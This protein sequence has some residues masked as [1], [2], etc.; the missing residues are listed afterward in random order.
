M[1]FLF[2]C[3][4]ILLQCISMS[5]S[6][7]QHPPNS[8]ER[9]PVF[10]PTYDPAEAEKSDI[11]G[12][13]PGQRVFP[14]PHRKTHPHEYAPI[15]DPKHR[16]TAP[17]T[18]HLPG[19]Q[20]PPEI[21]SN[22]HGTPSL[23]GSA[24]AEKTRLQKETDHIHGNQHEMGLM[25]NTWCTIG[26][27][28]VQIACDPLTER[29]AVVYRG[30]DR[31]R[32]DG[33][34]RRLFLRHSTDNGL[35]WA[36][37]SDNIASISNPRFPS[38]WLPLQERPPHIAVINAQPV[39]RT[40]STEILGEI[41][42]IRTDLQ[43][44]NP[45]YSMLGNPPSW[46]PPCEIMEDQVSG[47]LYSMAGILDAQDGSFLGSVH[48]LRSTDGGENWNAVNMQAP[49]FRSAD[50]PDGFTAVNLRL[51][52]SPDGST[53]IAAVVY[54][55]H[56]SPGR[57]K[58]LDSRHEIAWR[59]STNRGQSWQSW[60]RLRLADLPNP[61]APFDARLTMSWEMDVVF[62]FMNRPHFLTICSADLNPFD[63]FDEAPTDS[64]INLASVDST[65]ATE[66][67]MTPEGGWRILPVGPVRRVRTDRYS[68]TVHSP[69]SEPW[70]IRNEP[71]WARSYD[72]N[73]LFAK[74]ISPRASWTITQSRDIP[75]L[76][77]DSITQ[78]YVNA[79]LV[80]GGTSNNWVRPWDFTNPAANTTVMDSSMR[81]T[82]DERVGAKFSKM[83]YYSSSWD[84]VHIIYT[85]WGI[86][87]TLDD[88]AFW[89]DQVVWY[90][91]KVDLPLHTLS[92]GE[93]AHPVR[94]FSLSANYP[95]PFNP[96]TVLQFTLPRAAHASLRVY[97]ML[98]RE[99]AVLA[100]AS[101]HAGTH[102]ATFDAA[103][104]PGGM[105][106]ALLE[107][108]AQT[109]MRKMMLRR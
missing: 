88:D 72:G 34:G 59:I 93:D 98:G 102:R 77:P 81:A 85:E 68:F 24:S 73:K 87:E 9:L 20:P 27:N 95:N 41:H 39:E 107:S 40:D 1:R 61:P 47:D 62:D 63:I 46:T 97:D 58:L 60:K 37:Q 74:W 6:A 15:H 100:N 66:I 76:Y 109:A 26:Q 22:S 56:S 8:G 94:K 10:H 17:L 35:S 45:L 101:M 36:S 19:L 25:A 16:D 33:D 96:S 52:L 78:V 38:I 54:V 89:T 92:S 79:R 44:G 13:L 53:M 51:D 83:A 11:S 91:R 29:I 99:I 12:H 18:T 67:L 103:G 5:L 106:I 64:T 31:A 108:G 3:F 42:A 69:E 105:Y 80:T 65:F 48:L 43:F 28:F 30:N 7:Q 70:L 4:A 21:E 86:G 2:A 90:L 71:Q 104:L 57:A 23:N 49:V 14:E 84:R 82:W 32:Y 75:I 55:R 50:V